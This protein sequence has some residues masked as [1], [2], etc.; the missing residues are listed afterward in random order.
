MNQLGQLGNTAS[1]MAMVA[2]EL[3]GQGQI[4]KCC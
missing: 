2:S 4:A 3:V 1:A